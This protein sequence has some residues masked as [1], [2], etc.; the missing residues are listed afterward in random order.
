DAS[1]LEAVNKPTD[2]AYIIYTSGT[3]GRPKGVMVEHTSVINRLLWMQKQY[4][5]GAEDTIM[6]KTAITFDVSVWELFWWAFVGSKVLMLP[7]G[8]EKNPA[9]IV[10]AIERHGITTMHFV[11]SMLHA[12]LEHV[13]QLPEAERKCGLSPLR[14][15]FTSGEALLVSQ[16]ER[17]YR[18]IAPASDARLINL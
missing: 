1:N 2:M 17:F 7:V 4:P 16:V 14:Q 9:A 6:Q 15:V 18:Y 13:E 5:I 11:P 10:E 3:T 12:F 8:G